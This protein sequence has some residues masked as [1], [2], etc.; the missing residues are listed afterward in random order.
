MEKPLVLLYSL[1]EVE[2]LL[3]K[4]ELAV[5]GIASMTRDDFQMGVRAGFYG[6]SP[7]LIDLFIYEED[8]VK[9]TQ[10][11]QDFLNARKEE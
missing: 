10:I 5:N 8:Q 6:G 9:A 3:L 1:G 4:E 11:L 7:S 2:I